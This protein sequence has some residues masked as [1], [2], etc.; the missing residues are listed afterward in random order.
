MVPEQSTCDPALEHEG[1]RHKVEIFSFLKKRKILEGAH[2]SEVWA[3]DM[4]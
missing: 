2:L 4:G 3:D 1:L